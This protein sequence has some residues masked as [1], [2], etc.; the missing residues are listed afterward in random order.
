[1]SLDSNVQFDEK[2]VPLRH[3]TPFYTPMSSGINVFAQVISRDEN[4]Y[5]FPPFVM[6]GLLL[7]FL[8]QARITVTI[9]APQLSPIP[10]WWPILKGASSCPRI[11]RPAVRC[12]ECHYPNDDCF[13]FCQ[14][15]GFRREVVIQPKK[16]FAIDISKINKRVEELN[17]VREQKPYE[18]QKT[19]LEV[20]LSGFLAS[21]PFAKTLKS[22]TAH[23]IIKFLVWKD[24]SGRTKVH[25][26]TCSHMG[27][28][29]GSSCKCPCR[30]AAGTVDSL[31]GKLRA[32]FISAGMGGVWYDNL[33]TGNP[34]SHRSVKAYLQAVKEEQARA[35]V[36]PKKATP[37]FLD[38]LQ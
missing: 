24:K 15:C 37:L 18:R 31:I 26:V 36:R 1:M 28:G 20:E 30:L 2:G 25:T 23:D 12:R 11:W 9:I 21:L 5:V 38:K 6:M 29:Q 4:A 34:A 19:A 17:A 14:R 33:G 8:L 7:K 27:Q 3:F 32:I 22:A 16:P 13:M 10:Y 35:R